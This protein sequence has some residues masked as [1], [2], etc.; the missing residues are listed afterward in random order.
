M[1]RLYNRQSIF[2]SS[3]GLTECLVCNYQRR[4]RTCPQISTTYTNQPSMISRYCLRGASLLLR[5]RCFRYSWTCFLM[6][7]WMKIVAIHTTVNRLFL[8][9]SLARCVTLAI[10]S[11]D[12]E[13]TSLCAVLTLMIRRDHVYNTCF[14]NVSYI[15]R[16]PYAT[17]IVE[18]LETSSRVACRNGCRWRRATN[19]DSER[20]GGGGNLRSI[21]VSTDM[22]VRTQNTRRNLSSFNATPS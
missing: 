10:L 15:L 8:F 4:F 11:V 9:V 17:L 20:G 2:Q 3:F 7:Q 5:R 14:S 18:V 6:D 13:P 19:D 16:R 21:G 22:Y 1:E 12:D